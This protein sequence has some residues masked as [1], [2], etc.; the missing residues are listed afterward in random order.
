MHTVIY[1]M[2][3]Q[4]GPALQQRELQPIFCDNLHRKESEKKPDV[5]TCITASLRWGAEI[6]TTLQINY[7]SIKL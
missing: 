5:C 7:T 1:G 4:Q 2:T 3:G 6:I